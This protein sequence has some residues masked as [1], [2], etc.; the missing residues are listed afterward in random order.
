MIRSFLDSDEERCREIIRSCFERNIVLDE[1][2]KKYIFDKFTEEGFLS[3]E[4]N[5]Y[6]IMVYEEDGRVLGMGAMEGNEIKKMY[7][8]PVCHGKGIGGKLM[9]YFE[10]IGANN[11][12]N[13]I[14]LHAYDNAIDFYRKCGYEMGG[15]YEFDFPELDNRVFVTIMTKKL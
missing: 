7:V 11:G 8:D 5:K 2:A 6:S 13:E 9:S 3:L 12:A 1:K 10:E 15:K 14:E 4:K